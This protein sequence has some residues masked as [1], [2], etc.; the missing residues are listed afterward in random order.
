MCREKMIIWSIQVLDYCNLNRQTAEL[1][2]A[3]AALAVA[4]AK[5]RRERALRRLG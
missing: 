3:K 5:E 2:E 1:A 4:Q